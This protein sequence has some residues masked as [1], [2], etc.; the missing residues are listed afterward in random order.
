MW[1]LAILAEFD[2]HLQEIFEASH[3][4]FVLGVSFA[5]TVRINDVTQSYTCWLVEV[6]IYLSF[7]SMLVP[8]VPT[9]SCYYYGT[10][11][12]S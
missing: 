6:T 8:V 10:T 11:V 2:L 9:P 3:F 12:Q 1:A 5:R 7:T 4:H